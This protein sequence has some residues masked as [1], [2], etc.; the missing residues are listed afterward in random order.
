[1]VEVFHVI[2]DHFLVGSEHLGLGL[3]VCEHL[4]YGVISL[5][6]VV[7]FTYHSEILKHC[8]NGLIPGAGG[9]LLCLTQFFEGLNRGFY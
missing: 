2:Q 7:I 4:S 1:M 9:S 3:H 8:K 6:K 5:G